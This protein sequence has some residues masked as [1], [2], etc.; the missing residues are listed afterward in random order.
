MASTD[1]YVTEFKEAA[2]ALKK[3]Q[4]SGLVKTNYGY[5]IILKTDEVAA[6]Q[7]KFEDVAETIK[8]S[9]V[10]EKRNTVFQAYLDQLKKDAKIQI[11]N[12]DLKRST[13]P[14][15]STQVRRYR[16][17]IRARGGR[18]GFDCDRRAGARRRR[19]A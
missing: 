17:A 7:Q 19:R 15:T 12:K 18:R 2:D 11:L 5:H 1:T 8:A 10:T 4:M 13:P 16:P 3:G 6:G 9:L 14:L